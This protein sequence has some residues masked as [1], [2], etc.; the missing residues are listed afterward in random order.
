MIPFYFGFLIWLQ[1]CCSCWKMRGLISIQSLC[2]PSAPQLRWHL[3]SKI[4]IHPP[5]PL[6]LPLACPRIKIPNLL[7]FLRRQ[8]LLHLKADQPRRTPNRGV[9]RVAHWTNKCCLPWV[10]LPQ[11]Y[12]NW[13]R[14]VR[15]FLGALPFLFSDVRC[16]RA[17][18]KCSSPYPMKTGRRDQ[19][20]SKDASAC[21]AA[22]CCSAFSLWAP[23]TFHL[24]Q[25]R[26]IF[27]VSNNMR[28]NYAWQTASRS[29]CSIMQSTSTRHQL[30]DPLQRVA[31]LLHGSI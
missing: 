29:A 18:A 31:C 21:L 26:L 12:C 14:S 28:P 10:M 8:S 2:N 4:L 16:L 11:P 25:R 22:S 6:P 17:C 13:L 3:L 19:Q 7:F 27:L 24:L 15:F 5:L 1:T 23:P 30:P 9:A 20:L